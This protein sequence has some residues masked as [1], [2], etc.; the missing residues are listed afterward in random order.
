[1]RG[2]DERSGE[3]FSYVDLE[4]RVPTGHPL[5]ATGG[6][7]EARWRVRGRPSMSDRGGGLR[8]QLPTVRPLGAKCPS[9]FSDAAA[10]RDE[11]VDVVRL[12]EHGRAAE[13]AAAPAGG[14][15]PKHEPGCAAGSATVS[16]GRAD[17]VMTFGAA[18]SRSTL[19]P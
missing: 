16:M 12:V 15:A 10:T 4:D 9:A 11:G 13:L 17:T 6:A 19:Q 14:N 8:C 1:M 5:V 7:Y 3:L 18:P 2:T